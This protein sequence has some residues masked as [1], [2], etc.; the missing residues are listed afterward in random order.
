MVDL[1]LMILFLVVA[2]T[3]FFMYFFIPAGIPH[4]RYLVYMGLTKATWTWIHNKSAIL[5]TL[6]LCLHLILHWKWILWTTKN[7]FKKETEKNRE[8]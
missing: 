6:L 3:G 1:G 4:G 8:F 7:F 2:F 5:M